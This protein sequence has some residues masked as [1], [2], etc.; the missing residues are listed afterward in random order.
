MRLLGIGMVAG[1]YAVLTI[2]AYASFKVLT[3][4][5][6]HRLGTEF[7]LVWVSIGVVLLYNIIYNHFFAMMIKPGSPS[8]LI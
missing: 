6:P 8:D 5:I 2:H 7:G 3:K 4:L 1:L